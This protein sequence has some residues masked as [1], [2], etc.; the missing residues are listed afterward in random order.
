VIKKFQI[1]CGRFLVNG[2][3]FSDLSDVNNFRFVETNFRKKR[4]RER[5]GEQGSAPA[6]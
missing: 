1:A 4:V 2:I 5:P 3:P 6:S